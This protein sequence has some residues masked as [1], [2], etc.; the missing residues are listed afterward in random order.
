MELMREQGA[1]YIKSGDIEVSLGPAPMDPGDA[2]MKGSEAPHVPPHFDRDL[3]S[4]GVVPGM[5]L[6]EARSTVVDG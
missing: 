5:T 1:L 2:V 6:D 3:Y 4:D